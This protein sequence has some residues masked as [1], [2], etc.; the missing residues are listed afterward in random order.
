MY[1]NMNDSAPQYDFAPENDS[2]PENNHFIDRP[3]TLS[4]IAQN[5]PG[6]FCQNQRN[7]TTQVVRRLRERSD[8]Q[9]IIPII[10]VFETF[11]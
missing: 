5:V 11:G 10:N 4:H 2:T 3:I 1:V 7:V 6:T 9:R 8:N